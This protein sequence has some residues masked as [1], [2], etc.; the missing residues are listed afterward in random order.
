MLQVGAPLPTFAWVAAGS[1]RS[2]GP[3]D[4]AG[5]AVLVF[6]G[7]KSTE[8]AKDVSKAVRGAYLRNADVFLASIVDL[9]SFSGMWKRVAEAQ[10]KSTYEKLAAKAV[11]GGGT[12]PEE[13][14]I[15]PDWDGT[16]GAAFGVDQANDNPVALVFR[17]GKLVAT[18]NGSN[19]ASAVLAALA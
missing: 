8:F 14:V 17:N 12:G 7:S 18:A 1:E 4:T 16:A 6:H 2:V 13:V 5:R 3:K 19:A 9:R 11:E 10:V 15:V